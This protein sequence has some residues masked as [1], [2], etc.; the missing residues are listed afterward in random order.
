MNP[1]APKGNTAPAELPEKLEPRE[2]T[3]AAEPANL[4][5]VKPSL[6]DQ[7]NAHTAKV[8]VSYEVSSVT[9]KGKRLD[10]IAEDGTI[11]RLLS[12]ATGAEVN[13]WIRGALHMIG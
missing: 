13:A 10:Q 3:P 1:Q 9:G 8:G 6:I 11:K 4:E 5:Y 2:E 7:L 12:P